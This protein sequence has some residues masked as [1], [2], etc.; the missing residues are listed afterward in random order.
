[1]ER[2]KCVCSELQHKV[3]T[4]MPSPMWH[5][6]TCFLGSPGSS[7]QRHP[8]GRLPEGGLGSSGVLQEMYLSGIS[9]ACVCQ[10][11]YWHVCVFT[12]HLVFRRLFIHFKNQVWLRFFT[13]FGWEI[14][15]A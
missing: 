7:V 15:P 9:V 11:I 2:Q 6:L 3:W 14:L 5:L 4:W 13:S 10:K 8:S 1:M 12:K